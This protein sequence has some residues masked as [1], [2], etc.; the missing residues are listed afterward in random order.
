MALIL[1]DFIATIVPW[2]G[3]IFIGLLVTFT[4]LEIMFPRRL[5]VMTPSQRWGANFL[6]GAMNVILL[7]LILPLT[8]VGIAINYNVGIISSL[9][10]NPLASLLISLIALDLL[11]YWQHRLFHI[12]PIFWRFHKVHHSDLDLDASSAVRFHPGE[13]L[14]SFAIKA[15]AVIA[16]GINANAIIIFEVLLSS[17]A[18]FNHSNIR[19]G[20]LDALLRFAIVTP[21]MHRLH[22]SRDRHEVKMNFGFCLSIWDK[23]FGSYQASPRTKMETLQLGLEGHHKQQPSIIETLTLPFRP[24]FH[25]RSKNKKH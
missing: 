8:L 24:A 18:L 20:G 3:A 16:L 17:F 21:D 11:I 1:D 5:N 15:A 13:A 10:V 4:T 23:A 9:G 7:R 14:I 19:M 2:R 22:H 12:I 6:L 25:F